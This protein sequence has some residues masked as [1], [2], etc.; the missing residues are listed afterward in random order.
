VLPILLAPVLAAVTSA[1]APQS[2]DSK[3]EAMAARFASGA[4]YVRSQGVD[5]TIY[6]ARLGYLARR[7]A[8]VPA[9]APLQLRADLQTQQS[10]EF[11][12]DDRLLSGRS[13]PL[14][15]AGSAVV[16]LYADAGNAPDPIG[17]YVPQPDANGKYA[18]VVMLHGSQQTETDVLSRAVFR[19]LADT[20]HAILIAPYNGG[21]ASWNDLQTSSLLTLIDKMRRLFPIDGRHV[22]LLGMSMGGASA[23]HVAAYHAD[24]FA[25]V[26]TIVGSL[27]PADAAAARLALRDRPVYMVSGGRDPIVTP[28]AEALSYALLARGC[29][30]VGQY[31]APSAGHDLYAISGQL[32]RAWN[33]MLAGV[34]RSSDTRECGEMPNGVAP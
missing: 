3:I 34:V 25:G 26:M 22:Y 16:R 8:N 9:K 20:S 13:L 4:D 18:L 29:V 31:V 6:F 11:Q 5:P 15:E 7:E 27:D 14:P 10:L 12:L 23:F 30:S 24:R 1:S 28:A 2:P 32:E 33:D 21:D 19:N 17:V